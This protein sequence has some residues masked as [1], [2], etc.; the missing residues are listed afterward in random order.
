MGCDVVFCRGEW[1]DWK[2]YERP[3]VYPSEECPVCASE[4]SGLGQRATDRI[5]QA[6][7][8]GILSSPLLIYYWEGEKVRRSWE[9]GLQSQIRARQD[10]AAVN[11]SDLPFGLWTKDNCGGDY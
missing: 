4:P 6:L 3:A 5:W 10:E 11:V 2:K 7:I 8:N 1:D 9:P